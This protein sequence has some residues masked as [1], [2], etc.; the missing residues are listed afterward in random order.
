MLK[1]FKLLGNKRLFI[2]L[3]GLILFIA[4][5]GFTLGSR[6]GLSWPEKFVKDTVGFVQYVFY[7]PTS[8]VAG[9]IKDISELHALQ[10]EN[11]ELKIALSHYTRDK[12]RFN[13]IEQEYTRLQND[14]HFTEE[15]KKLYKY[16]W[17]IAQVISVN[18]DPVN[19]TIVVNLG[20]REGVKEGMAVHSSKGLVGIVSRVSTLTSTVKLITT[21][22]AR[23]PN[24]NGI[25]V[26]A[27]GKEN[28]V[29]GVIESYDKKSGTFL[30]SRIEDP[31]PLAKEDLIVSS[32]VGGVFPR[33]MII[34]K[35]KEVK[36]G[37]FGLTY[38]ATITPAASFT[39]WKELF[40]V[41]PE[42]ESSE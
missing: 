28:S 24:S 19:Q 8:Y 32:G 37:E 14:L 2:L 21:M 39:D 34:G 5:M 38:T 12:A 35:V 4:I 1:L 13:W 22:D 29:F 36:V 25:A 20:S 40:I 11:E 18:D 31:K 10:E 33:G 6:A 3:M 23:D 26:T 27:Q 41:F 30:M 16:D 15:Q 9:L 7:K 17:K 42:A